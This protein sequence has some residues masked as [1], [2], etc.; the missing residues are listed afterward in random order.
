MKFKTSREKMEFDNAPYVLQ[1][2]AIDVDRFVTENFRKEITITRILRKIGNGESGVHQL[3]RA[4]DVRNEHPIG[5]F[6]FTEDQ[7]NLIVQ[8]FNTKYKRTDGYDICVH[9]D[10]TA[11]H[12]HF[13]IPHLMTQLRGSEYKE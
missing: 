2:M 4:F 11:M 7:V 12:F 8:Y 6:L 5:N 1:Q 9:H 3:Y 10:G 13:Q